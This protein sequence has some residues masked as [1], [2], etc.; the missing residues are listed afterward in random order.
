MITTRKQLEKFIDQ[1]CDKVAQEHPG[2]IEMRDGRWYISGEGV[3]LKSV[4]TLA[5][6]LT[7]RAMIDAV[8]DKND[9]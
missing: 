9:K 3:R 7:L 5:V 8:L 6:T 1:V 4:V 2:A